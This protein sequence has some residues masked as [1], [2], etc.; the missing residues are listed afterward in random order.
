MAASQPQL[1]AVS[2]REQ[3]REA[4]RIQIVVGELAPGQVQSIQSVAATLGVSITPV[5]EAVQDLAHLGL[6]EV[7]RNRGFRVPVLTDH[8]LDEIFKVR[9]MLEAP[10]M[11]ELANLVDGAALPE[12]RQIAQRCNDAALEGDV[13]GFLETDRQFH[14][15]LLGLL[16]NR[17]LVT[18]VGLLRDQA[19]ML[20][21]R[22]LAGEGNLVASA[23]EHFAL[24]DAVESGNADLAALLMGKHLAHS[25][26][27]WA[28]RAED[29]GFPD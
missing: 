12:F 3:A 24:L 9:T 10:A 6:V 15:G 2:L 5:R 25:R 19:R 11:A 17:R 22:K 27:I 21:L 18:M 16:Q 8:D 29:A 23:Q 1:K 14:L 26:G 4:V 28:G 13:H 20:G 7:I